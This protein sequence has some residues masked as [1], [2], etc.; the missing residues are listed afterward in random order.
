MDVS[1][2]R[3]TLLR[4]LYVKVKGGWIVV[5]LQRLDIDGNEELWSERFDVVKALACIQRLTFRLV[6][7][8]Q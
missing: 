3:S 2:C 1:C 6:Q 7:Q 8:G 5:V 4:P